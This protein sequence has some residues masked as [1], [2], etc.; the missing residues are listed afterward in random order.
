MGCYYYNGQRCSIDGIHL[1][2]LLTLRKFFSPRKRFARYNTLEEK[3]NECNKYY[4]VDDD[5]V[6]YDIYI[7]VGCGKCEMC[8]NKK[9]SEIVRRLQFHSTTY[10]SNPY[11][12]TLTYDDV[13]C[14]SDG[15]CRRH[16][17]LFLKKLRL[18]YKDITFAY[19]SEYGSR[20]Y[21]PHYHLLVWGV[22]SSNNIDLVNFY[23]ACR[24]AWCVDNRVVGADDVKRVTSVGSLKRTQRGLVNVQ[25]TDGKKA[26]YRY[27]GKYITKGACVPVGKNKTFFQLSHNMGLSSPQYSNLVNY[28]LSGNFNT[29]FLLLTNHGVELYSIP[30]YYINKVLPSCS[31]QTY[32]S[33]AVVNLWLASDKLFIHDV[34]SNILNFISNNKFLYGFK[35]LPSFTTSPLVDSRGFLDVVYNESDIQSIVNRRSLFHYT[36][37]SK[38]RRSPH[39]LNN[40]VQQTNLQLSKEKL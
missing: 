14:P 12:V 17:Q 3:V 25:L 20:S 1:Q 30:S 33:R 28:L 23:S 7:V 6:I 4:I 19:C 26:L 9:S 10:K 24:D 31:R 8:R 2:S 27:V 39:D 15:V 35:T 36:S 38:L 13:N 18:E 40:I 21:R 29:P 34:P 11:F 32:K 16:V 22:P 5:G 37:I